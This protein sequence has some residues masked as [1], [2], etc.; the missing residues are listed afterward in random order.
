MSQ[1]SEAIFDIIQQ[2]PND[3]ELREDELRINTTL[4]KKHLQNNGISFDKPGK[5]DEK[6]QPI[7]RSHGLQITRQNTPTKNIQRHNN[8]DSL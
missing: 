1:T 3:L 8:R 6:Q 7:E 5:F 4:E 2:Y